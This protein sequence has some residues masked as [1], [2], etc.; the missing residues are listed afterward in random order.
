LRRELVDENGQSRRVLARGLRKH[1]Q[2]DRVILPGPENELKIVRW[3]F[4]QF[5]TKR[6]SQAWIVRELNRR[7][8]PN[9]R[10]T[11]WGHGMVN[12]ILKNENYIGN[13]LYNRMTFRLRQ[14][15]R[16]N[17]PDLWIR[18]KAGF[19]PIVPESMFA[20]AQII[21]SRTFTDVLPNQSETVG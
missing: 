6:K 19:A 8:I 7:Q 2:T 12:Y 3:I 10:G 4:R 14:L 15:R 13:I 16:K 9:H 11:L 5:A 18:S 21:V 17:A 1:L 20:K